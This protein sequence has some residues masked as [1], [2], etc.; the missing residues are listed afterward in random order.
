[1]N[2]PLK[3]TLKTEAISF[4]MVIAS[5]VTSLI[6]YNKLPKQVIS[7]WNFSG[8][9]DGWASREFHSMLFP[10]IITGMY[11]LFLF[12]PSLDPKKDRYQDF[13]K[14][15]NLFRTVFLVV[16]YLIFLLATLANLGY[17][18]SIAKTVPLIIG[19][20]MMLIGNYMGKI[21]NNWFMGI[22]TPWTLS[23]EN[24]WNKT[25]RLGG[26]MFVLFGLIMI[27]TPYLN[28][29]LGLAAFA[30]GIVAVTIIPMGYSY[31]LYKRECIKK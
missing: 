21:K 5:I 19:L 7:H 9:P 16:F 27:A 14:V 2:S 22:R 31:I 12:L 28:K 11:V 25:H 8:T 24:V 4:T 3:P 17:S 1:M 26:W 23:S 29:S 6:T 10:A 20:L 15:Y 18:I 13:I 30:L